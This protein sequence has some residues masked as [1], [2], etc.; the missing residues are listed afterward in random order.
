M[1]ILVETVPAA[2]VA[3]MVTAVPASAEAVVVW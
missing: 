3:L 2:V 1:V